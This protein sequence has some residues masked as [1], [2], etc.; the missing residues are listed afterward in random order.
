MDPIPQGDCEDSDDDVHSPTPLPN[1]IP[2]FSEVPPLPFNVITH[3]PDGFW[4]GDLRIRE[5]KKEDV[6]AY[7]DK[8]LAQGVALQESHITWESCEEGDAA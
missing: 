1:F 7:F 3:N 6:A 8:G 2:A 4:V 5:Q